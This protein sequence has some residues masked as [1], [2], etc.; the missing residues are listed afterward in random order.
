[1]T[2]IATKVMQAQQTSSTTSAASPAATTA[3]YDPNLLL[4][5]L[6]HHLGIDSDGALS[7]RLKVARDVI[8]S[9]RQGTIPV[10]ASMLLWM[11]EASG[12]G[13]NELRRIMGDRRRKCRLGFSIQ[14]KLRTA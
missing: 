6:M 9:I 2:Q 14:P 7:R 1:M 11:Q 5:T 8:R 12:I 4:D 13:I 3:A 10:C